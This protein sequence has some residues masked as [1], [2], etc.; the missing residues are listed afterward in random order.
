MLHSR[1]ATDCGRISPFHP[2]SQTSTY[3]RAALWSLTTPAANDLQR[4]EGRNEISSN[5][6]GQQCFG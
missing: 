2:T 4:S 6:Q 5:G 3:L 1:S